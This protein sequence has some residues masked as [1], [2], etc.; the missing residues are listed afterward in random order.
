LQSRLIKQ[1]LEKIDIATIQNPFIFNIVANAREMTNI[2]TAV[3][4]I[5]LQRSLVGEWDVLRILQLR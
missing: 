5:W 3:S 1:K 4:N 2:T